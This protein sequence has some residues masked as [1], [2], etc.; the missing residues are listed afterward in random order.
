MRFIFA[1]CLFLL[2]QLL[3]QPMPVYGGDAGG[4]ITELSITGLKRTR[5]ST[6]E[7]ALNRFVGQDAETLDMDAVY[8]A[9]L[10]TGILEP[11]TISVQDAA[12]GNGKMLSVEVREKWSIFPMPIFFVS[13]GQL[14]A[15]LFLGD[16]NAFGLNDKFFLGGMYS[17]DG[18]ML[19]S[20]YVHSGGAGVPGWM[21]SGSFAQSERHDSDQ[22][23]N[24]IR[25]F[26]LDNIGASAGLSYPFTDI[27]SVSLK[28]SYQQITLR[29]SESPLEEPES[30]ARVLGMEGGVSMRKSH[31]DGYLLS[32]KS[33]SAGYKFAAGIASDSFHEI[34]LRSVYQESLLPGFKLNLSG[35]ALYQPNVPP[36]FESSPNA[37]QVNILPNSFS[38]RNYAGLSLGFEKYLFKISAGILSAIASYQI[39]FSE[40]PI[41]GAR[42]DHGAA[43]SLVFYLR[44]LAIPA[45]GLGFAY[46]VSADYPQFYFSVGMSL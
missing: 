11:I 22:N 39:V 28:V 20:S 38:A 45:M 31:W 46:N 29:D 12:G 25:R 43:A 41:I 16:T 27:L 8:A 10:D 2:L 32:E 5:L 23:G 42:L 7:S 26:N 3:P 9:V 4:V 35:G 14:S 17:D 24:D 34:K 44:K 37:A 15:G 6:V 18:W 40:G 13:S 30:G 21:L 33:L 36:L 1:L 19:M